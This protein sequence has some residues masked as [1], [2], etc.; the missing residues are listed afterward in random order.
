M[1]SICY[2][3]KNRIS[4]N[5]YYSNIPPNLYDSLWSAI[6]IIAPCVA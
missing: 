5:V 3:G 6:R 2:A 4:H 1:K